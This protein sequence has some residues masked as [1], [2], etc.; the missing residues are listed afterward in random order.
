[1]GT[2]GNRAIDML[3]TYR[4]MRVLSTP[5]ENQDAF[6]YGIIDK[7]GK[8]LR[9]YNTL[10]KPEEKK[11]YTWLHR[12]LFNVKRILGK[13]GLGS[14]LGT[15]AAALGI[16][17]KEGNDIAFRRADSNSVND[18]IKVDGRKPPSKDML[19]Q[20][21]K[22]IESS[23]IS[24]CKKEEIWNEIV[25]QDRN[26]PP[27]VEEIE[28]QLKKCPNELVSGTYFGCDVYWN[29]RIGSTTCARE[30]TMLSVAMKI[31]VRPR[32]VVYKKHP[33]YHA[34]SLSAKKL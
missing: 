3:I 12:F 32:D 8:V 14:R 18:G 27:L 31:G 28:K 29:E 24:Y 22:V 17:L 19:N 16:L 23:I 5:F 15:L 33:D 11:A 9:K 4:I 13:V 20:Y 26:L 7:K 2:S 34:S 10:S 30:E 6:K 25:E 1:M 21:A